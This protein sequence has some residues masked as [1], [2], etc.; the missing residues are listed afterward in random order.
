MYNA[1]GGS[2]YKSDTSLIDVYIIISCGIVPSLH[3]ILIVLLG[4]L[5]SNQVDMKVIQY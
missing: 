2:V 4:F 1:L 5:L 3:A